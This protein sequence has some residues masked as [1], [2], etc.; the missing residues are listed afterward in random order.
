MTETWYITE[1]IKFDLKYII[2]AI[3]KH[4]LLPGIFISLFLVIDKFITIVVLNEI[5]VIFIIWHV[6]HGP[7]WAL[8]STTTGV[9]GDLVI[10]LNILIYKYFIM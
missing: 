8:P 7:G 5:L 6:V 2:F 4:T 10:L 1:I 9:G 3:N